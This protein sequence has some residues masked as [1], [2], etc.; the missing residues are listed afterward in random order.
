MEKKI[1]GLHFIGTETDGDFYTES[2]HDEDGKRYD[3]IYQFVGCRTQ[4]ENGNWVPFDD[5]YEI[6]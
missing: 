6:L 4:D 3:F 5:E 2:Y 1:V